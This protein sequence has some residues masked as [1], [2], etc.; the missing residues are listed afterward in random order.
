MM[1]MNEIIHAIAQTYNANNLGESADVVCV[2]IEFNYVPVLGSEQSS[3]QLHVKGNVFDN[4]Q[5]V[6][7]LSSPETLVQMYPTLVSLLDASIGQDP[8]WH[9]SYPTKVYII[10]KITGHE[11]LYA[12]DALMHKRV[13]FKTD[14]VE[15]YAAAYK[16]LAHEALVNDS[17]ITTSQWLKQW[18]QEADGYLLDHQSE[19]A[20]WWAESAFEASKA[21]GKPDMMLNSFD[22]TL[23]LTCEELVKAMSTFSNTM[24]EKLASYSYAD[25]EVAASLV[26][27][28][29]YN[30][31]FSPGFSQRFFDKFREEHGY[32]FDY[33]DP[34]TSYQEDV[35]AFLNAAQGI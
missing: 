12:K 15:D 13:I 25:K 8:T 18:L 29:I 24:R 34:D 4:V 20:T 19:V 5:S 30:T 32:G 2:E 16:D 3:L 31:I 27:Q 28:V 35:D 14:A 1:K 10:S 7:P 23:A 21:V 26:D 22:A 33:Y 6:Y 11:Q 9:V 17:F